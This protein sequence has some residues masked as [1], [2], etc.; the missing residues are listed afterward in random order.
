M[1]TLISYYWKLKKKMSHW[2]SN[3]EEVLAHAL[4]FITV[5]CNPHLLPSLKCFKK[6]NADVWTQRLNTL[7]SFR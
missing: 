3:F 7:L 5:V 4:C 2:S 6:K 1:E